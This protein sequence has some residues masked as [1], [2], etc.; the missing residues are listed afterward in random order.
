MIQ[1]VFFV[2]AAFVVLGLLLSLANKRI[3][4]QKEILVNLPKSE[5]WEILKDPDFLA[6]ADRTVQS[7]IPTSSIPVGVGY[8]FDTISHPMPGREGEYRLSYLITEYDPENQVAIH[9]ERSDM[10]DDANWIMKLTDN[11]GGTSVQ[12]ELNARFS[13]GY[14]YIVPVLFINKKQLFP[15]LSFITKKLHRHEELVHA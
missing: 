3:T 11:N 10:F 1:T 6:K 7:V 14:F 12:F 8:T 2:L 5:V 13:L 15:D 9:L 4:I